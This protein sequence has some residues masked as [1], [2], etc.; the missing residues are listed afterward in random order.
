MKKQFNVNI[1]NYLIVSILL[2]VFVSCNDKL[3]LELKGNAV[4][5]TF[6][7]KSSVVCTI[8]EL[9]NG[10]YHCI[11]KF[12]ELTLWGRFDLLGKKNR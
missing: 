9:N 6:N 3:N 2:L 11:G 12:D 10:K 4:N 8:M 1:I 7:K 5:T